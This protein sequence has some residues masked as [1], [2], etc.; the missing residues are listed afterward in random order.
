MRYQIHF[1]KEKFNYLFAKRVYFLLIRLRL[2][3]FNL[4]ALS[5]CVLTLHNHKS[6][7][8][9]YLRVQ[10]MTRSTAAW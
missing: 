5:E 8:L 2:E 1:N 4:F 7:A 3:E 9:D 10:L 6:H